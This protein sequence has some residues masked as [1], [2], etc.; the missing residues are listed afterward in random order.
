MNFIKKG[1]SWMFLERPVNDKNSDELADELAQAG[2]SVK[3]RI[4][5]AT[6]NTKNHGVV[7]HIIGIERWS[8]QRLR[9]ARGEP[10]KQEEYDPYRPAD[11]TPW[12][13]LPGLFEEARQETVSLVRSL[14][15]S[16]L[17]NNVPH[18]QLGMLSA[19]AWVQYIRVHA[20]LESKKL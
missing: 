11:D 7:T 14:N 10:L 8:Q 17:E 12:S 5:K 15:E 20:D 6:E 2:N 18:N 1:I 4:R 16:E 3:D 19:R 13:D 9:A